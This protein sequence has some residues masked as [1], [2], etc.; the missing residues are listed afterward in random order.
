MCLKSNSFMATAADVAKVLEAYAPAALQDEYDNCG[1]I[2]GRAEMPV[3]GVLLAFDVTEAV[4]GEAI[5]AGCNMI[6]SHH[7]LIFRG[8]KRLNGTDATQRTVMAAIKKDIAIYAAHTSADN[9]AYGVS[10]HLGHRLGLKSLRTL[11]PRQATHLK[12]TVFV[13]ADHAD[14][15][16]SALSAAGAG[17]QGLYADCSFGCEGV[18]TFSPLTGA[19]PYVGEVGTLHREPEVRLEML[20][21]RWLRSAVERAIAEAHPYEEPAYEFTDVATPADRAYGSGVVGELEQPLTADEFISLVKTRLGCQAVRCS[22]NYI[23]TPIT[24]VAACGGAGAFLIGKAARSGV[25]AMVTA[26]I[27]YHDFADAHEEML[28]VDAGHYET[29][30]FITSTF[31]HIISEKFHNFAVRLSK[32]ARNPVTY[33]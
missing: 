10:H 13:P 22:A 32:T 6:V 5:A 21:P 28:L 9:T 20:L 29:E 12:L 2:I 7:P 24:R 25:Q 15:L 30:S 26:D 14:T 27:K 17:A 23:G 1:L 3:T 31:E 4:I 8:I 19:N 16:R 11:D 33:R 18:G